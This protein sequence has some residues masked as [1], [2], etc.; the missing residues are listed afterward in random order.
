MHDEQ[1]YDVAVI[2]TGPAG[3]RAAVQ[4]AKVGK[5]VVAVDRLRYVG[6]QAVHRGTIPSKTLREAVMHLTGVA[7]RAFYGRSYRVMS[8]ITMSDLMRRTAQVVQAEVELVRDAFIRNDIDLKTGTAKFIGPHQLSVNSEVAAEEIEAEKIILATGSMPSRPSHIPFDD[9]GIVDSDGILDLQ[10]IPKTITIVGA[11]VIGCEY[12][13]IFSTLGVQVTL[14]DGRHDLLEFVDEEITEALKYRMRSDGITLRLGHNVAKVECDERGLAVAMLETGA[15]VISSTL[16]YSI[17]R[18]GATKSLDLDEA[19]LAAD[20]RGRLLVN[21]H[22]Q[23]DVDH[24]YAVGDVIGNPQ[25]AATSA[26][27][28][29][30]A[31]RHAVGLDSS[32]IS[33]RLPIGIYTIPE[34]AMVGKT[35]DDLTKAGIAYESG[36]GRYNEIARGAI[37]GDDFGVVKVLFSPEDRRILGVHIFGSQAS[38]LLHIGQAVMELDGT[39]DYFVDTIFN[40]PTFAEA[41][42]IAGLNGLNKLLR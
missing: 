12:A 23:T 5:R 33:D 26:E 17:G 19:D 30:L 32:S 34:I 2:G 15:R 27:Q 9:A 20:D 4:A 29:R 16:M 25:L 31:A 10:R 13:S 14:I 8:N 36:I 28:G 39:I 22:Y 24:I 18:Q 37:V 21:E 41:Y 35:E 1:R 40:Y 7:Q 11:G 6:G 38:E 42:K 3:Q